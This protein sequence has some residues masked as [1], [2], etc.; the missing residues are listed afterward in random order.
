MQ[1]RKLIH[2]TCDITNQCTLFCWACRRQ[3][4]RHLKQPPG[5]KKGQ[6]MPLGDVEK[7]AD[8]FRELG[9]CG[10]VSDPIFHPEFHEILKIIKKAKKITHVH[11]AATSPKLD[12]AFY[13]KCF[14]IDPDIQWIFG[15]DGLPESSSM[16]RVGQ[17]SDFLFEVMKKAPK[18]IWQ[19]I[20]FN[21]NQNDIEEGK[22]LADKYGIRL[23][24]NYSNRFYGYPKEMD[25]E[26]T[27]MSWMRPDKEFTV[28]DCTTSNQKDFGR[29]T[30]DLYPKCLNTY[31]AYAYVNTG[32]I[33]P[34]CY[35]DGEEYEDD[36]TMLTQEHLKLENNKSVFDIIEGAEYTDFYKMLVDNP[37]VAPTECFKHCST[38]H[39][40]KKYGYDARR[41]RI[42]V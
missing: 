20:V 31:Q 39:D 23:Q 17:D 12:M 28:P 15:I 41:K 8:A 42:F 37:K 25:Y 21:Y 19:W 4:Y 36:I 40:V 5:G 33:L 14:E 35:V 7:L 34:C 2:V 27:D 11:T 16:Y 26:G 30:Y 13:E 32:F 22:E 29:S 6:N 10:Q 9:L 24:L 3:T 18:S 1:E 38:Y